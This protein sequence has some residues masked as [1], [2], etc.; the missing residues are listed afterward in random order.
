M[1]ENGAQALALPVDPGF[2][3]EPGLPSP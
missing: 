2:L 3:P 1:L